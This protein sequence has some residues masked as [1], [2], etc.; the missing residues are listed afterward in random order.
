MTYAA[1]VLL[2]VQTSPGQECQDLYKY[3]FK[4]L[5]VSV[6]VCQWLSMSLMVVPFFACDKQSLRAVLLPRGPQRRNVAFKL[7]SAMPGL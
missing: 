3:D 7:D 4:H 5:I 6:V 2:Q 1:D